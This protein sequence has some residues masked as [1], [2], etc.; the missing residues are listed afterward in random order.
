MCKTRSGAKKV[1]DPSGEGGFDG[2]GAVRDADLVSPFGIICFEGD[3]PWSTVAVGSGCDEAVWRDG[4]C[5][6]LVTDETLGGEVEQ[7]DVADAESAEDDRYLFG[8]A[9]LPSENRGRPD[10][11]GG[12]TY[13]IGN[14]GVW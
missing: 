14:F 4:L 12:D 1:G 5:F 2:V 11:V 3:V 7:R 10:T 13:G 8:E 9:L 6:E